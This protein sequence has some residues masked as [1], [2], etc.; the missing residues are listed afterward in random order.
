[1]F[2]SFIRSN[3]N[4]CPVIWHFCSKANTEKRQHRGLKIDFNDYSSSYSDLFNRVNLPTLQLARLR[5]IAIKAFKYVN[6]NSPTYIRNVTLISVALAQY[7][8]FRAKV[9]ISSKGGNY[10]TDCNGTT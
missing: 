6:D 9:W 3:F 10:I 1:M 2:K 5:T 4:Y 8:L 7:E